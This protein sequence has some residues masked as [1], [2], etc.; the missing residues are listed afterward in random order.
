MNLLKD[1]NAYTST[2]LKNINKNMEIFNKTYKII[3]NED[4]LCSILMYYPPTI[5]NLRS[6]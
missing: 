4:K 5:Y 1:Q 2:S 6:T 3:S